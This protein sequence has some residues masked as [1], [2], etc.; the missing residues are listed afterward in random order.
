MVGSVSHAIRPGLSGALALGGP[1]LAFLAVWPMSAAADAGGSYAAIVER[2]R[3]GER[4]QALEGLLTRPGAKWRAEGGRE[5]VS[6]EAAAMLHTDA[7]LLFA[8]RSDMDG[9]DAQLEDALAH[10]RRLEGRPDGAA[11]ALR[12]YLAL[13]YELMGRHDPARARSLLDAARRPFERDARL[14]LA[15]GVVAEFEASELAPPARAGM[16][17][18]T[19]PIR[20]RSDLGPERDRRSSLAEAEQRYRESL[21]TDAS[22]DEAH[23][24]RGRVLAQLGRAAEARPEL[25]WATTRSH[26]SYVRYLAFLFLG[27]VDEDAGRL[28]AAAAAYRSAVVEDPDCQAA[29]LALGRALHRQGDASGASAAWKRAT[30]ASRR[31]RNDGWWLYPFGRAHESAAALEALRKEASR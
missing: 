19:P 14:L 27:R 6:A 26:E 10:V 31:S 2:Y 16:Q 11:F 13:G 22:L 17:S 18:G 15:L 12:W 3:S 25:E 29:N 28:E 24:R 23:L 7:A 4:E 30:P 8:G 20:H 21:E 5:G 9:F 1:L